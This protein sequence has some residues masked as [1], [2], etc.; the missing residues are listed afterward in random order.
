MGL[1]NRL[2]YITIV[3]TLKVITETSVTNTTTGTTEE[4]Y[5]VISPESMH[6]A[7]LSDSEDEGVYFVLNIVVFQCLPLISTL[8]FLSFVLPSPFPYVRFLYF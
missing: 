3:E 7:F 5:K 6:E 4:K 8:I 1:A 2:G